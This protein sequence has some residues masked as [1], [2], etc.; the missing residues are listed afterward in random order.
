[1]RSS[2]VYHRA[3]PR[4]SHTGLGI[5]HFWNLLN[6][7]FVFLLLSD[8]HENSN[9]SSQSQKVDMSAA[10]LDRQIK[11]IYGWYQPWMQTPIF[12]LH[13]I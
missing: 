1:M 4:Y 6:L 5:Y 7:V 3:R 9:S 2:T 13:I 10:A 11:P 8:S 12:S